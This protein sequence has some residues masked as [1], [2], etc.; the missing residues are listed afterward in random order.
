MVK[1][2]SQAASDCDSLGQPPSLNDTHILDNVLDIKPDPEFTEQVDKLAAL[3]PQ[4]DRN[5]LAGYLRRAGSDMLA[6]GQYL[7][8]ERTGVVR[9]H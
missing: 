3:V 7:E 1:L 5:V 2:I 6:I 4:A 8:D 9:S